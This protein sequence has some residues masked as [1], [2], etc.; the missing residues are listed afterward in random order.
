MLK[1]GETITLSF[2]Y[3]L[4]FG[5]ENESDLPKRKEQKESTNLANNGKS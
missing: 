3:E 5:G 2:K 4:S 1:F